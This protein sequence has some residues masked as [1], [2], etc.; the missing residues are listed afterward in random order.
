MLNKHIGIPFIFLIF[1]WIILF[2][3]GSQSDY[4]DIAIYKR[5]ILEQENSV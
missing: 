5:S 4:A 2:T 3:C 1:L